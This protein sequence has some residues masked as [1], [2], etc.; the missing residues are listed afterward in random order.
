MKEELAL[1]VWKIE[2]RFASPRAGTE[3][4]ARS[5]VAYELRGEKISIFGRW[6]SANAHIY[7]FF[8]MPTKTTLI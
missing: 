7:L 3:R 8:F 2:S 4:D 5:T 1:L 6:L